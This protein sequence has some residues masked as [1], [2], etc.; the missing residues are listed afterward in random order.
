MTANEIFNNGMS[1]MATNRDEDFTLVSYVVPW[2][3]QALS[4]CF[5]AENSIR[6]FEGREELTE[7]Q[8]ITTADDEIEY[9]DR[10]QQYAMSYFIASFV[11]SDDGDAYRAEDFRRRFVV[12]LSELSKLIPTEIVDVYETG[13]V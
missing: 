6:K 13:D 1:L 5:D 2:I 3:N 10:L 4:E 11:A 7:P 12:A 8:Q 9:D